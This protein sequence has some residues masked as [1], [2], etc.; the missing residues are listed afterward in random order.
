MA[1]PWNQRAC[2]QK[3]DRLCTIITSNLK[4]K[5][6]LGAFGAVGIGNESP[7]GPGEREGREAVSMA[8]IAVAF[9][10]HQ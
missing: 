6:V 7:D 5:E 1:A 9:A 2:C 8:H 4:Y 3:T 10:S